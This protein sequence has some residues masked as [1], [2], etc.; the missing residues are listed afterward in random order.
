MT[1]VPI[2]DLDR[3]TE[4]ADTGPVAAVASAGVYIRYLRVVR[5]LEDATED[6]PAAR[7]VVDVLHAV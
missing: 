1:F 2:V 5:P 7:I 6:S 3:H 4:Q